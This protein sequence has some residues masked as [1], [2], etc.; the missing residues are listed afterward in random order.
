MLGLVDLFVAFA[1]V[2]LRVRHRPRYAAGIALLVTAAGALLAESANEG[3]VCDQ[4]GC[5]ASASYV[6]KTYLLA[7]LV[8]IL[9][10]ALA[11]APWRA[12]S[13]EDAAISVAE[14]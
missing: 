12:S 1:F 11:L 13:T 9:T 2:G 3:A 14:A 6:T 5:F 7:T 4:H 10:A 8:A